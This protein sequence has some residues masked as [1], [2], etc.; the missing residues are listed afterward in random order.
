MNALAGT[1]KLIRVVLRRDRLLLPLWIVVP[2]L[3]PVVFVAAFNGAYPTAEAREEYAATSVHSTA[4]I[5]AYGALNGSS[6][7]ELVAWR[8]GFVP[9]VIGL[10]SLLLVIR[11]TR[12][13]EEA[14]RRELIGSTAVS[15]H[16]DL[17]AALITTCAA[18]LALGMLSA[19]GLINAGLPAAGSV[20]YGAGIAGVG[21]VFA[22]IGGVTAQLSSGA[23]S[24]RGAGTVV[25]GVAF[26][27]RGIGDVSAQ[28]GGGLGWVSWL[29]PVG[30]AHQIRPFSGERWWFL[31]IVA[32]AVVALTALAVALSARRDIGSGLFQTRP[33]PAGAPPG[34]RTPL[35][36]AWRLH[37]K[38]LVGLAAGYVVVGL[39]L[40]GIAKSIGELLDNSSAAA[41]EVLAGL[42]VQGTL[43]DQYTWGMMTMFA[44]ASAAYAIQSALRLRAEES[45]GRAEPVLAASVG[46]LRWAGSHFLFALLGPSLGMVLFGAAV[47]FAHG[48]NTGDLGREFP[49]AL[50]AA[51]VQ[52]PA[53]W[54]FAGLAFALFGLRPRLAGGA[55]VVLL[56]SLLLS[57]F[58]GE[59]QLGGWVTGLSVFTHV[60]GLP[61]AELRVLPLVVLTAIAAA[62]AVLGLLGLRR[63]DMPVG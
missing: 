18:N 56:G 21:C 41:H 51:V 8:A 15:R 6:L 14:G 44:V 11:H 35:A 36:L 39:G 57:W 5:V 47:G 34:L 26:L 7:A 53:V 4:F 28:S 13:E 61:G 54:V 10:V 30:W 38:S 3:I 24:A 9:V 33:G 52:L 45:G 48:M 23:G 43:V 20:A 50:D 25:L 55:F 12:A 31:G 2:S 42:G 49:R 58:G 22:A 17:A 29:S 59:L 40:G 32:G 46:R 16:A 19:L 60:P 1:G 62:L 27:L 63:R 37:R